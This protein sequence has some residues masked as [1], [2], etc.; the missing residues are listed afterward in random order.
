MQPQDVLKG[1]E[2]GLLGTVSSRV[3]MLADL[4]VHMMVRSFDGGDI[5]G[6]LQCHLVHHQRIRLVWLVH[7]NQFV[8]NQ[9][10]HGRCSHWQYKDFFIF[11]G[12]SL[13]EAQKFS[14]KFAVVG[15]WIKIHCIN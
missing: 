2:H 1:G 14:I 8:V 5:Y 15:K 7:N 4:L 13:T 9:V 6:R 12:K 11:R 3:W 10:I